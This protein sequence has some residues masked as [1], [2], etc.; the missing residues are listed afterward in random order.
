MNINNV[1]ACVI[2]Y[3]HKVGMG[4]TQVM[5]DGVYHSDRHPFVIM[6]ST[7]IMNA[8]KLDQRKCRPITLE[9]CLTKLNGASGP[10]AW[11]GTAL[12]HVFRTSLSRIT[13]LEA[14]VKD[15]KMQLELMKY[16]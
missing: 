5:L 6:P 14:E 7:G 13:E 3:Y 9:E 8:L 11:E 12:Q 2:A 1:L 16:Q 4:H 15:L 10:I